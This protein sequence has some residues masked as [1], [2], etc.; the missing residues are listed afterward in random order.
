MVA[1]CVL[2]FMK[3]GHQVKESMPKNFIAKASCSEFALLF[4]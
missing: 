2:S 1:V 3:V 4:M